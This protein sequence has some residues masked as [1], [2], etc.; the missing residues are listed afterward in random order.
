MHFNNVGCEGKFWIYLA[1]DRV[2]WQALKNPLMSFRV[3]KMC[4]YEDTFCG[5]YRLQISGFHHNVNLP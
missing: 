4:V 1:Q 2:Q 3:P 5:E